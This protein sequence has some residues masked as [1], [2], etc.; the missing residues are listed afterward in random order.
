MS[1]L[2]DRELEVLRA[3]SEGLSNDGV[4]KQLFISVKTVETICRSVFHKL[5]LGRGTTGDNRRVKAVVRYLLEGPPDS[6]QVPSPTTSFVGRGA[7]LDALENALQSTRFLTLAGP[8]GMGKTRLAL[9]IARR[10]SDRGRPV[11]FID[12]IGVTDEA[13]LVSATALA[14]GN[15]SLT[16]ASAGRRIARS[17]GD[18]QGLVIFDNADQVSGPTARWAE[19]ITQVEQ[20]TV[21]VTSRTALEAHNETVRPAAPMTV[22]DSVTLLRSRSGVSMLPAEEEALCNSVGGMPLAIELVAARLATLPPSELV[23]HTHDLVRLL[24]DVPGRGRQH[25]GSVLDGALIDVGEQAG[26]AAQRLSVLPGGFGLDAARAVLGELEVAVVVPQLVDAALVSFDGQKRYRMLEPVRQRSDERLRVDVSHSATMSRLVA[27]CLDVVRSARPPG[28]DIRAG[29]RR[30][31][32]EQLDV[33]RTNIEAAVRTA[34]VL[35][36]VDAALEI[37]DRLGVHWAMTSPQG[38]K[39]VVDEVLAAVQGD[40]DEHLLSG[41]HLAAGMLGVRTHDPRCIEHLVEAEARFRAGGHDHDAMFTEYWLLRASNGRAGSFDDVIERAERSGDH[42]LVGYLLE[43]KARHA[44]FNGTPIA[45]L[46]P[47]LLEAERLGRATDPELTGT[48]LISI[49]NRRLDLDHLAGGGM[50]RSEVEPLAFEAAE[51]ATTASTTYE[52]CEVLL[53]D[54][55]IEQR[56]GSLTAARSTA[57][58]VLESVLARTCVI[59]AST[60][61]MYSVALVR[62]FDPAAVSPE[63]LQTATAI[64]RVAGSYLNDRPGRRSRFLADNFPAIVTVDDSGVDDESVLAAASSMI[65]LLHAIDPTLA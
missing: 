49:A 39:P 24:A 51:I 16:L 13:G 27:W 55:R 23:E 38:W 37:V 22:A 43:G 61:L 25:L 4:A 9:E 48:A 65:E 64:E 33:E 29:V 1:S 50:D 15:P 35:G 59:A 52:L 14:V 46:M 8:G 47:W 57:I 10:W 58:G 44:Y 11:R 45:E 54:H 28:G 18:E 32:A 31:A 2:S 26:L 34:L 20:I 19:V 53:L 42:R 17:F 40:E 30:T 6:M 60:A 21:L 63:Q 7:E 12:L 3:L 41:A 62:R 56:Y 36:D 5:D